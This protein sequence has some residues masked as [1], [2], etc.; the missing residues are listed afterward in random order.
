VFK[1]GE[2]LIPIVVEGHIATDREIKTPLIVG[3]GREEAALLLHWS[4]PNYFW[5]LKN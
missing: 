4:P 1:G 3:T 5:G 2:R